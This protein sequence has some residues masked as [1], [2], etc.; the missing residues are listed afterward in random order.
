MLETETARLLRRG[1]AKF[2]FSYEFQRSGEGTETATPI[3]IEYGVTNRL[4]LLVE[5]VPYTAIRPKVGRHAT[6]AGDME[7]TLTWLEH[8]ERGN[9][10]AL[11]FAGEAKIPTARNELIGTGKADY[12]FYTIA[13]RRRGSVQMHANVSYTFVGSP[14]ATSLRNIWGGALAAEYFRT[15][16]HEFFAEVLATT[17]SAPEGEG[18]D[19]PTGGTVLIPE[20]AG[21]EAAGSVGTAYRFGP[22]VRASL[23]VT[24]DNTRAWQLRTSVTLWAR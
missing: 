24:Y 3:G 13:S 20:A 22:R 12:A 7:A 11:A 1:Q 10:P 19:S 15:P 9:L 4:E 2:D 23:G 17:A 8:A 14:A 16:A 5:P 18:G 6:G 21:G